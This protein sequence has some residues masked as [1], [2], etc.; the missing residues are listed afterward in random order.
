MWAGYSL[1]E[2][3]YVNLGMGFWLIGRVPNSFS[4]HEL[5]VIVV[6]I[7]IFIIVCDQFSYTHTESKKVPPLHVVALSYNF[8]SRKV[9][10][11]DLSFET[12]SIPIGMPENLRMC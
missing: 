6:I 4:N 11:R 1:S 8:I 9:V 5:S 12:C 3:F 7:V 10:H 2:N